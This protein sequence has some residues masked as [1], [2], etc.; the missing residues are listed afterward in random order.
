MRKWL[1]IAGSS[2]LVTACGGESGGSDAVTVVPG[3]STAPVPVPAASPTPTPTTPTP[4]IP[5][6]TPTPSSYSRFVD[7]AGNRTFQTACASLILNSS[8]PTPQ[9]ATPFGD[10]L[11]LDHTDSA[12][13]W[14]ISGE[15]IALSFGTGDAVA[16]SPG[17]RS[18]ERAVAGSVQRFTVTDP[19]AAGVAL[20]YARSFTLRAD[21]SAGASIY[22]CVFGV[23]TRLADRPTAPLS[24]GKV[25]V[26]GTAY[27]ADGNGAMRTYTL[28]ASTGTVGYD[29]ASNAVVVRMRLIGNLQTAAGTAS[30]VTDLGTFSGNGAVNASRGQF[31][32]QL[33]GTDR[34]S[35]FSS[36]G[37]WFFGDTEA[38]SAFEIL[39][40]DPGSGDRMSVVGTVVA[41]R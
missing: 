41:V 22:S 26:N 12:G 37:G 7:L 34:V 5:T 31:S 33:D 17:Q 9:P 23:P 35:L 21:R 24:Y 32:G 27:V 16:T 18:F 8:P 38:A 4:V 15:G 40:A 6:P 25:G 11:T 20:E 36:F 30:A 28:S 1:V 29:A 13:G 2:L 10:G 39:A 3:S 19:V 14:T